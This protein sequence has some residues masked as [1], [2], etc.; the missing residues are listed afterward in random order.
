MKMRDLLNEETQYG[1]EAGA[2]EQA[3]ENLHKGH[4]R[5]NKKAAIRCGD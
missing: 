1:R 3:K 4:T 2:G 5:I